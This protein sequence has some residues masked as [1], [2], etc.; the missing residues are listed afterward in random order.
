MYIIDVLS[1]DDQN[2]WNVKIYWELLHQKYTQ[3]LL[4]TLQSQFNFIKDHS[5]LNHI[6]AHRVEFIEIST[7]SKSEKQIRSWEIAH[8]AQQISCYQY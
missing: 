5:T 4:E 8:H 6:R 3:L 2:H 7:N 1:R